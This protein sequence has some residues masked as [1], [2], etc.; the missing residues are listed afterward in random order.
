MPPSQAYPVCVGVSCGPAVRFQSSQ[1][2]AHESGGS[3]GPLQVNPHSFPPD[4]KVKLRCVSPL[5]PEGLVCGIGVGAMKW[6][7]G[8]P[9][10]SLGS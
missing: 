1:I 9:F 8:L 6:A 10:A 7:V 3:P 4:C 5:L 2:V